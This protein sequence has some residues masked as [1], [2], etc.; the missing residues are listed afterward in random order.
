MNIL[1]KMERRFG[2]YAIRDLPIIMIAFQVVGYTLKVISPDVL[3]AICFDPAKICHGQIWRLLTWVLMPPSDLTIFTVI[4]LF[5]YYWI[6]RMLANTWGDFYFNVYIIGGILITDI[7]M[8]IAYPV[9]LSV[10]SAPALL[11]IA[12]MSACVTTYYIQTSILLAF[13]FTYPNAQVLL[14]FII[15]VKMSWLGIFEGI[16]L[17][18]EFIRTPLYTQKL[19]I[20]LSV[21]NFIIYFLST[22]DLRKIT[23]NQGRRPSGRASSAQRAQSSSGGARFKNASGHASGTASR[24]NASGYTKIYPNGARHRCTICGRTELDDDSLEF[25]Y[26]SKCE[27]SHEYCQD[28]LFTHQHIKNGVPGGQ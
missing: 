26:C 25:R 28:H 23:P 10:G 20:L 21:M 11:S 15:P 4:M 6:A 13:A 3:Y 17:A 1:K 27:G 2:K 19:V 14:Y 5:F 24:Q 12:Y 22:R 18:Y 16:L 9:F 7:G 8:M